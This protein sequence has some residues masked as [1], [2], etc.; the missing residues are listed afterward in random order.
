MEKNRT[1]GFGRVCGRLAGHRGGE[2]DMEL[3]RSICLEAGESPRRIERMM[4]E[5][6]GMSAVEIMMRLSGEGGQERDDGLL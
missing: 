4:Y 1:D 3:F 2:V 6:F 5:T